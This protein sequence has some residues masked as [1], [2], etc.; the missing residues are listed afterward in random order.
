M[1]LVEMRE[2][3]QKK[4]SFTQGMWELGVAQD[5]AYMYQGKWGCPK[6]SGKL[7]TFL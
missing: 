6:A 5:C 3:S 2:A 7:H 1:L 4:N